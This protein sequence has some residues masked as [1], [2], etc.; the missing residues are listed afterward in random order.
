MARLTPAEAAT[1]G[2]TSSIRHCVSVRPLA[3]LI[4][5]RDDIVVMV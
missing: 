4:G 2:T 5:L 3:A 1:G